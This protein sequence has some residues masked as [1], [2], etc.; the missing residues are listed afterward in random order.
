MTVGQ[1][2]MTNR[3]F[4][5]LRQSLMTWEATIILLLNIHKSK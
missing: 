1:K 4:M 3:L 5:C 2:Y